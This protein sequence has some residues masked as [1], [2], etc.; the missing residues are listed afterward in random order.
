MRAADQKTLIVY[1]KLLSPD[2]NYRDSTS[3]ENHL[4][5]NSVWID[6]VVIILLQENDCGL[7]SQ[8][9]KYGSYYDLTATF[10]GC[11]MV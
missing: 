6:L 9:Q 8:L 5:N 11:W 7:T 4:P 3:E 10:I 2:G 1:V